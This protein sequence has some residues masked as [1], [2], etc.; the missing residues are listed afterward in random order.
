VQLAFL[1]L[2]EKAWIEVKAGWEIDLYVLLYFLDEFFFDVD[3]ERSLDSFL[4][5]QYIR[6]V[7]I[8]HF[9]R[10]IIVIEVFEHGATEAV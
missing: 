1:Y 8:L 7:I 3:L 5:N 6:I 9:Y 4:I 10:T 2:L